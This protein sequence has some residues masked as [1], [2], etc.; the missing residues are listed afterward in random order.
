MQLYTNQDSQ[1]LLRALNKALPYIEHVLKTHKPLFDG[2]RYL[3]S[4]EL[5]SILKISRRTLQD[6]RNN[7]ILPFIQLPG[8]V[9]FRE[10]DIKKILEDRFR[11]AYDL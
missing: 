4:E 6:Y 5:C 10:S 8:K 2:E 7:G 9:L 11:P 1:E 3:T